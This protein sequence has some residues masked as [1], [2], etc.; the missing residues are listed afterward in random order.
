MS[1]PPV[2]APPNVVTD[3]GEW[4]GY[5]DER[6]LAAKVD[7]AKQRK[8]AGTMVWALDLDDFAGQY[9]SK[10]P[11]IRLMRDRWSGDAAVVPAPSPSSTTPAPTQQPTATPSSTEPTPAP[12]SSVS[13]SATP[14]T[15]RETDGASTTSKPQPP[16]AGG[17]CVHNADCA[18]SAWCSQANTYGAWCEA[19]DAA[20]CP[21]PQCVLTEL[22]EPSTAQPTSQSSTTMKPTTAATTASLTEPPAPSTTA[23]TQQPTPAPS[24]QP[25]TAPTTEGESG[26]LDCESP[27]SGHCSGCLATNNVCYDQ[28]RAWCAQWSSYK[29]C[30]GEPSL[31]QARRAQARKHGFLGPA[32]LQTAVVPWRA[33]SEL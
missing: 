2:A 26:R 24:Q 17:A 18:A 1:R 15:T 31:A 9:G 32:L 20:G 12:S 7:F 4:I 29:W 28:P 6:S 13:T 19:H 23:A 10:Y 33:S 3:D 8:L 25:T 21:S 27:L 11:L 16:V 14:S 30:G 5:D 22:P